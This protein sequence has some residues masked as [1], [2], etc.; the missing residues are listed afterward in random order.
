M[1][2]QIDILRRAAAVISSKTDELRA[3]MPKELVELLEYY[4]AIN[5]AYDE[6]D[7]ARKHMYQLVDMLNKGEIPKRMEE[8]G[9]DKIQIPSLSRSFYPLAKY[10]ASMLDKSAAFAWLRARKA[11]DLIQETVNAG[12]LAS[13]LKDLTINEG[14]DPPADIF[15]F[16]TYYITGSSAYNP[17]AKAKG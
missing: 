1:Q 5:A 17:K 4:H 12:T 16:T 3:K 2:D 15:K 10:S 11:G 14:I 13:Y 6:I 8:M 9:T 7:T